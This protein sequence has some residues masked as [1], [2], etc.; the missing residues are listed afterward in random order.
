MNG[1][2]RDALD[3]YITGGR[4]SKTLADFKCPVEECG[5]TWEGEVEEEYGAATFAPHE[6]CPKCGADLDYD[7]WTEVEPPER[8][9]TTQQRDDYYREV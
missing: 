6:Q 5:E 2:D 4:Y 1:L 9:D 8:F 7:N 3:R